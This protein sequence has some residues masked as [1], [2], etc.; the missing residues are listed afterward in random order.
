[1]KDVDGRRR[2]LT[3]RGGKGNKDRRTMLPETLV[4]AMTAHLELALSGSA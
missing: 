1:M 4:E 3:V 2:V